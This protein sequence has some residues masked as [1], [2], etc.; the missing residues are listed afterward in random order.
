MRAMLLGVREVLLDDIARRVLDEYH[1]VGGGCEG[2][3]EAG[4]DALGGRGG[5][6]AAD[7]ALGLPLM[8]EGDDDMVL[9]ASPL[10]THVARPCGP[11]ALP[12][13]NSQFT[14]ALP[15]ALPGPLP[16]ALPCALPCASSSQQPQPL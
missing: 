15:E 11:E 2:D 14:E 12:G 5:A 3:F 4:G 13:I 1:G 6:G 16:G 7:T 8:V 10:Q 9:L